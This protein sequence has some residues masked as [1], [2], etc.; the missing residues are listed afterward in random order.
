MRLNLKARLLSLAVL[1]VLLFALI[2]SASTVF[3][4]REQA[5]RD[6][7][8]TR[9]H[10]LAEAKT[11]L[12]SYVAVAMGT[13][14][15]LYDASAPGDM[16]ARAQVIKMLSQ[17]NYAKDGYFF[18]YDSQAVRLFKGSSPDGIGKSFK[19]ARDPNGVYVNAGL[20]EVAKAG[21]HYLEYSSPLPGS[22]DLVPKLGYS[23]YL[24]KWD[25]AVGSSVN[26]DNIDAKVAEVR[27]NVA[28]RMQSML[29]SIIGIT[30]LVLAVI[31]VVGVWM[32]GSILRP[33]RLMKANLDDIAAGEGDLTRRLAVSSQDEL[34][35]L[36]SSFNRFVDKIHGLVKQIAEMTGQLTGLVSDV[37]HQAQRSEQAMERQR[38]ETD[39]VATAI[40][41][42]SA[43]AQE[44]AKSAQGA[45]VAAQQTDAQGQAA[46]RVVDGSIQ[47]IHALVN[48]IRH[49]GTSLD[50]LQNDVS[51]IVGVLGVIRSIA[52]QTNLLAL[53]AAIEA[54]RAGEHGRGF[55]VVAD[56]VRG[57]AAR[58]SK[59]T[60]EIVDVVRQNNELA[61]SAVSSMQSSLSRTGTGVE[62]ANEA[63]EVILEIQQ[64]SRHVVDAISQ[65]NSTLQ[66]D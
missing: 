48:D 11:T 12:Q 13:I 57:L 14:K 60:V 15:P 5:R 3:M 46:K 38:H 33:L 17:V 47:Q 59:A 26:L 23:E 40:N 65:F 32:A 16:E 19:D 62:L 22:S 31:A 39:Q 27:K 52:E 35:E 7:E 61:K 36:A 1:P 50:S 37:T 18:G 64:G 9:Q 20:V 42:M 66:L 54:A 6:V 28:E 24:P 41:Q 25:M 53:N 55:A 21:T 4:L 63:G 56:E 45:S 10:L 29:V 30:L 34:G 44:V 2:V 49:S 58:T 51:S 8:E 43:A